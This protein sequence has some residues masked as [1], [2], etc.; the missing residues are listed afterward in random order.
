[1]IFSKLVI[2]NKN[3]ADYSVS[4]LDNTGIW[5]LSVIIDNIQRRA[6]ARWI[7]EFSHRINSDESPSQFQHSATRRRGGQQ[8]WVHAIL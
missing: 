4:Y 3:V 7:S 1:M 2:D 8:H 5:V 6:K